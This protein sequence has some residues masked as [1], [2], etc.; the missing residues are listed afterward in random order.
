M[1]DSK[2]KK[3]EKRPTISGGLRGRA[4]DDEAFFFFFFDDAEL[5]GE[6]VFG[7]F[8]FGYF[9]FEDW[10]HLVKRM[11]QGVEISS[12]FLWLEVNLSKVD[13]STLGNFH[14]DWI[15]EVEGMKR[16]DHH[17]ILPL[18]LPGTIACWVPSTSMV[19][20]QLPVAWGS[21][22]GILR[23]EGASVF[24]SKKGSAVWRFHL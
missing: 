6:V 19:S 9:A 20:H 11:K 12:I 23:W 21:P 14:L 17:P 24:G 5:V 22:E 15:D 13:F 16:M 7:G 10:M 18:L 1:I 4:L 3:R 2:A 8:F